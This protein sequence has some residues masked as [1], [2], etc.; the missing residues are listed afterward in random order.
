MD[1]LEFLPISKFRAQTEQ[2]LE[3][4]DEKEGYLLLS[5]SQPK[6]VLLDVKKYRQTQE[7]IE[8]LLDAAEL[9]RA[10]GE[11]GLPWKKY[12]KH[13]YGNSNQ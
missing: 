5:R 11:K 13:R 6:A 2:T 1:K 10:R 7:L 9:Q 12:L 8:D 3:L 4:L